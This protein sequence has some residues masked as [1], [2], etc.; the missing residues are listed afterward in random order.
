[1]VTPAAAP[2]DVSAAL[3]STPR[4][5]LRSDGASD[6]DRSSGAGS[7]TGSGSAADEPA[8]STGTGSAAGAGSAGTLP[9]LCST[10][11]GSAA[12]NAVVVR[13]GRNASGSR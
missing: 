10:G 8:E 3:D 6:V 2:R 1:V 7:V 13:A 5:R 4:P 11:T 9:E 12:G